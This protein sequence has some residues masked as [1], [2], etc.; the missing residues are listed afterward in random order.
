VTNREQSMQYS[1]GNE[2]NIM[3]SLAEET[4][5]QRAMYPEIFY[6]LEPFICSTCDAIDATGVMP[7]QE[8]LDNIT[9]GIYDDF[10]SM[11]P[12]LADYMAA[13]DRQSDMPE[14]V[15]TQFVYGGYGPGRFR[16]FRRRGLARD[17]ISLLLLSRLFGRRR[18]PFPYY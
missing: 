12:E 6:K 8:E 7:T 13:S 3:K 16:G 14:A 15:T 18:Y 10:R 1:Y 4:K 17:L 2:E 5:R 11:Y 9:D